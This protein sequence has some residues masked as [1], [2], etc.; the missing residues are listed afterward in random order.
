MA[1][2]DD[3][4]PCAAWADAA[5]LET[6]LV[7]DALRAQ[8]AQ[9][10]DTL[11]RIVA[12]EGSLHDFCFAN[13]LCRFGLQRA[14]GGW[15]YREWAPAA[16][17]CSLVGDFN[18]WDVT[19]HPCR[20]G[21]DGVY[22][23]FVPDADGLRTG[24][25][26]KVA[27]MVR[28]AAGI[29]RRIDC[30]PAWAARTMQ[31]PFTGTVYALA[32][33]DQL[34]AYPWRHPRPTADH[35]AG[36]GGELGATPLRIY[37]VHVG[38]SA[39]QP[40][41][42]GWSHF[43][44]HV[45]P[46]VAALGY[47]ALLIIAAQEHGYYA[48]FGY[49]VTSFF[50]PP[51]RFGT[52]AELQALIDAAHG[53]GLRVL[54]ELVHSHASSN[55]AEGLSGFDGSLLEGGGYFLAGSDGWHA[56]WGTRMFDFGKLEVLRFLL[57]QLCW[58]AECY[59]CDGFRFDAVS[60]A[61]Y[62]H[63]S[64]GGAGT[65]ERGY[66]EYYDGSL[67]VAALTYFKV[68]NYL[69]HELVSPPLLTIAEEYSG[70]PG[71]CAPVMH[72][73]VGFDYR[74]AMGLPPLWQRL[75]ATL[76]SDEGGDAGGSVG[77]D[78]AGGD[79]SG[80]VGGDAASDVDGDVC[81]GRSATRGAPGRIDMG[82]LVASMCS[83]RSEER[84]VAYVECH[85]QSIVGGQSLAFRCM[86]AEMYGGMSRLVGPP[87]VAVARGMALHKLTRL[88][89]C[90][91]GGE[92]YL[93]FIGNEWGHPEW[94]DLPR[95]GN[96]HSCDRARRRWDLAD[97]P[98]LRYGELQAF[99]AAM[100]ALHDAHPWLLAD[101]PRG[102]G[103]GGCC[104]C[105]ARQALWFARGGCWF[106]F[107]LHT[108]ATAELVWHARG[109]SSPLSPASVRTDDLSTSGEATPPRSPHGRARVLLD[110]DGA[111]F[112]GRG[113]RTQARASSGKAGTTEVVVRL[114]ALAA[115]VVAVDDGCE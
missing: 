11:R 66:A 59:R 4:F 83:R 65:F 10:R 61:L 27:L 81:D 21:S 64:L 77:S 31:D 53:L 1:T 34:L 108:S 22:S 93:N 90:A 85:D 109:P 20:A 25:K 87:S 67:D 12:A 46:R 79:A 13:G 9:L 18:G 72:G 114:P 38:I 43:R 104:C 7:A 112:G 6:P 50:A 92:A 58:Y 45:L 115:C 23:C 52:P 15:R 99:D 80:G 62:R 60:A 54:L 39:S 103:D 55:A 33:D 76:C 88:L 106:A 19:R 56:E 49:Q 95:E 75:C 35:H 16:S 68:A 63:R 69:V 26:Y 105:E 37:E 42:A 98:L 8:D 2:S 102:Q 70:L 91:L 3:D 101:A 74:Q 73:G 29:V 97:D 41:V 113:G 84:R 96:G 32:S 110:S 71:L 82:A 48:S 14:A 111:R 89:A 51:S 57:A 78:A 86:G 94:V 107:N 44:E 17:A 28:S 24:D 5:L 100:H 40:I 47:T 36:G 30:V